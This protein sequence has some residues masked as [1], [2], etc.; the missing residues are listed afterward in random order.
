MYSEALRFLAFALPPREAVWWACLC[1]RLTRPDLPAPQEQ[2]VNAAVRWVI[3]P[4]E[5]HRQA[6]EPLAATSS[7]AGYAAKAV[8]WTGGSLLPPSL[9]PLKPGPALPHEAALAAVSLA[10]T[11]AAPDKV[12]QARRHA[13]ALGLH[14][15]RGKHLWAP[16]PNAPTPSAPG[17]RPRARF[18]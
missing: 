6:A 4:T 12:S 14:V 17:V 2:A 15:A 9:K 8:A 10:V 13:L 18:S 11:A 16:E 5:P 7:S 3:E 1:V